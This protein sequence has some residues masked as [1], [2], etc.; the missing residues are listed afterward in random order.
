MSNVITPGWAHAGGHLNVGR[1]GPVTLNESSVEDRLAILDVINRYGWAYDERQMEA[2]GDAF[3]EDAVWLGSVRGEFPIDPVATRQGI[4]DWLRGHMDSQSDQR[5]HNILNVVVTEQ[6]DS[7]ARVLTYLL[8][9]SVGEE[10]VGVVTTGVYDIA[11]RKSEQ[12]GWQ[13][14]RFFGG[15]DAPF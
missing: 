13:I 9:T 8:L 14:E 7:S 15:F 6:S 3:T 11:L 1:I 10:G 4:V 2:L 12:Q 5:R